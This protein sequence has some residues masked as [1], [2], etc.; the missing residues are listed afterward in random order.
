MSTSYE[1]ILEEYF[2]LKKKIMAHILEYCIYSVLA[3]PEKKK[4][5]HL[6]SAGKKLENYL[7]GIFRVKKYEALINNISCL[8]EMFA[9]NY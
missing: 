2:V 4:M 8:H 9:N 6:T 7:S 3:T 1:Q 5:L